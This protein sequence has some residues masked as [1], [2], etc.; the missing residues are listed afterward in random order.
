MN[1]RTALI[2]LLCLPS[3]VL[4]AHDHAHG[5]VASDGRVQ[6]VANLGQWQAGV[7]YKAAFPRVPCTCR[8]E[9]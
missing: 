9:A 2:A 8:M 7:R 4:Q 5:E 1:I 3:M 6:Y